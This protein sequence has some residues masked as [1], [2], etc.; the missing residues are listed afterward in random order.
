MRTFP[1]IEPKVY[2]ICTFKVTEG[3]SKE[4]VDAIKNIL[5][6]RKEAK[7]NIAQKDDWTV[8]EVM[9]DLCPGDQV[10]LD[11]T[12]DLFKMTHEKMTKP[13]KKILEAL[14]GLLSESSGFNQF[15]LMTCGST[16]NAWLHTYSPASILIG[17]HEDDTTKWLKRQY[18]TRSSGPIA[19]D[20]FQTNIA[21]LNRIMNRKSNVVINS[22]QH[23][24][25][26]ATLFL[27]GSAASKSG[28]PFPT[29]LLLEIDATPMDKKEPYSGQLEI[30][31]NSPYHDE[32]SK[33]GGSYLIRQNYLI[34]LLAMKSKLVELFILKSNINEHRQDEFRN[35]LKRG[36]YLKDDIFDLQ[37]RINEHMK[38]YMPKEKKGKKT[39]EKDFLDRETFENEKQLLTMAS[40]RFSLV[41]EVE[42]RIMRA[43]SRLEEFQ[44]QVRDRS[45]AL[46]IQ[47]EQSPVEGASYS[48]DELMIRELETQK[49]SIRSLSDELSHSRDILSS[50]IDVLRT[51]IDTRQRETSEEMS[52][53]M[54]LLFLVF[55]CIGLADALGNFV[56][57]AME[58]SYLSTEEV[59]LYE[60]LEPALLGMFLTFLPLL[61]AVIFIVLYFQKKR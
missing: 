28:D 17:S 60:A 9:Y 47:E 29:D 27:L 8:L 42:H 4:A 24:K 51:F 44:E 21:Y 61:I 55:A 2:S 23:G 54:N 41:S 53:L 20:L 36:N 39:K 18:S 16:E 33:E 15:N 59:T 10:F 22:L 26:T 56:V 43:N 52:R 30:S 3:R 50:T 14:E 35:I 11:V 49:R 5:L 6:P 40:V 37:N 7:F 45:A 13:I 1:L 34:N 48:L 57:F 32:K 46:T 58:Y 12:P 25:V 31:G 38:I 19:E